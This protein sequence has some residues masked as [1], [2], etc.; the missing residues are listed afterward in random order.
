MF[1]TSMTSAWLSARWELFSL[2]SE[3]N[4][5]IFTQD[6]SN[7]LVHPHLQ[8]YPEDA[9]GS[10]CEAWHGSKWLKDMPDDML[11]PMAVHPTSEHHFFIEELCFC[12]DGT[13]FIP[14]Q[15]FMK[16]SDGIWAWG[17]VVEKTQVNVW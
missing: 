17:Y 16:K 15:W 10:M 4:I 2:Y 5:S 1:T 7:P 3:L 9:N 11:T 14:T 13:W 12:S 8:F 6:I